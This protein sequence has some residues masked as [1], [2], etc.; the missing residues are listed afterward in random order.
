MADL[1]PSDASML[2]VRSLFLTSPGIGGSRAMAETYEEETR[3][4]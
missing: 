1:G 4:A 3:G 2:V